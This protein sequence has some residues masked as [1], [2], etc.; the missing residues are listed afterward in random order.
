VHHGRSAATPVAFVENASR[1]EQRVVVGTLGDIEALA[2]R[3][4]LRSPALL[5]V[6]EVAAL[7]PLLHWFG[8]EP[9]VADAAAE[10]R[11]AA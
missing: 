5:V 4:A 10:A 11:S 6:G 2:A 9:I 1:P 8:D 7:A 3:H